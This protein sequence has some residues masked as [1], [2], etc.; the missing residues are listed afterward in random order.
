[1][2]GC[3]CAAADWKGEAVSFTTEIKQ[4]LCRAP[5]PAETAPA[6]PETPPKKA[7][8]SPADKKKRR[9]LQRRRKLRKFR[10]ASA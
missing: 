9:R 3:C 2:T 7:E 6:A 1:M 10:F 5:A 8:K 4:E